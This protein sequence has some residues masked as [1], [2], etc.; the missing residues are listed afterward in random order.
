MDWF[1]RLP[2]DIALLEKTGIVASPVASCPAGAL[3]EKL[4][5]SLQ[6]GLDLALGFVLNPGV[7]LVADE[8]SSHKVVIIGIEGVLL[9]SLVLEAVQECLALQ[10]L[11][12]VG[13]SAAGHARSSSVHLVGSR[14]LKVASLNVRCAEPVPALLDPGAVAFSADTLAGADSANLLVLKGGQNPG[15]QSRG[16]GNIVIGH[17]DNAGVDLGQSLAYLQA[18]VGD[19]AAQ[20]SNVA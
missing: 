1:I 8:P 4:H 13:A 10:N 17:D 6:G 15:H 14:D 5:A 18:L 9:P 19:A 3:V 20:D 12:P 7:P 2:D 11:G 16:P